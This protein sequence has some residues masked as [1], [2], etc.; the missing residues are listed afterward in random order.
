MFVVHD[1]DIALATLVPVNLY[2]FI[3]GASMKKPRLET[4]R[5]REMVDKE[6]A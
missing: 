6:K 2:R 5:G 1:F 4:S 3:A